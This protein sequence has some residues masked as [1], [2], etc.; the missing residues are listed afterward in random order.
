MHPDGFDGDGEEKETRCAGGESLFPLGVLGTTLH[1]MVEHMRMEE[2]R[3]EVEH[4][5]HLVHAHIAAHLVLLGSVPGFVPVEHECAMLGV[6]LVTVL[7]L[8]RVL[9]LECCVVGCTHSSLLGLFGLALLLV[10][11]EVAL[12]LPRLDEVD[13]GRLALADSIGQLLPLLHPLPLGMLQCLPRARS[14]IHPFGYLWL[15]CL[16]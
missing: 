15:H 6:H 7:L 9:I 12:G 13:F 4:L 1:P 2:T 10:D 14:G 8:A 16:Q 11:D 5:L 3:L